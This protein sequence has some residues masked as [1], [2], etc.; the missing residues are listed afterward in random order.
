MPTVR[1]NLTYS[2]PVGSYDYE[3]SDEPIWPCTECLPWHVEV[4]MPEMSGGVLVREWHAIECPAFKSG[5]DA[6]IKGA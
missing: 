1:P 3:P 5:L 6:A 4:V 2:A